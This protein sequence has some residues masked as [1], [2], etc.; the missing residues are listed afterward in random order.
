ML[1]LNSTN[2]CKKINLIIAGLFFIDNFCYI[3]SDYKKRNILRPKIG[4]SYRYAKAFLSISSIDNQKVIIEKIDLMIETLSNLQKDIHY[5]RL[6]SKNQE[7]ILISWADIC[8][9]PFFTS[10]IKMIIENNRDKNIIKILHCIKE[11]YYDNNNII[12]ILI[13]TF[14]KSTSQERK[15][16]ETIF[17]KEKNKKIHYN[18]DESI[19]GGFIIM[20]DGKIKDESVLTYLQDMETQLL[21]R[22]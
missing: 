8:D 14:Q 13:T 18:V 21:E 4:I 22:I 12:N 9:V 6:F 15:N 20:V 19:L 17:E 10:F 7:S 2:I 1:C 11:I 3:V 5:K 16:I